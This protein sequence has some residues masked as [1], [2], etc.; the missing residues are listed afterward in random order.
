MNK[1]TTQFLKFL[2]ACFLPALVASTVF[3]AH[4]AKGAEWFIAC[5]WLLSTLIA[6]GYVVDGLRGARALV[7]GTL[8]SWVVM[9]V[10]ALFLGML[11]ALKFG[12]SL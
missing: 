6:I 4:W 10:I 7:Y 1:D 3:N 12:H 8:S 5:A 11:V 2:A 9:A